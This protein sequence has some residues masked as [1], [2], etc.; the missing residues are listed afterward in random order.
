MAKDNELVIKINGDVKGYQDALKK[1]ANETKDLQDTLNTIAKTGAI[2]F[3][4]FTAAI[5]LS[6]SRFAEFDDGLRGVKTLLDES[7]FSAKTLE[8]GFQDMSKG[9]LKSLQDFPLTLQSLTK[10]LFDIVSAGIPAAKAINVLGSTSRLAVAGIT[11]SAIATDA[12][13][14]ALNAYELSAEEAEL[15]AAK[16]FTA[17]KFGKTTIAELGQF[18]G[19][20]ASSAAAYGVS[21]DELLAA[22][23]AM[24]AGGIKTA[25]AMSAMP[26]VFANV[27]KP[28]EEAKEE[29][30]R[31]GIEFNTTAL[32]AKGLT[33]FLNELTSA[34]GFTKQSVEKL[35][36]SV[37]AQ[38]AIFALTGA[39]AEKYKQTLDAL[40]DSQKTL[41]TFT[42][43]YETQNKSLKNQTI[44]LKNNFDALGISIG[45]N[46][47]PLMETL[48]KITTD[49]L[50]FLQENQGLAAFISKAL[51]TGTVVAGLT[52]IVGLSGL[53]FLKWRIALKA[54]KVA[55]S[56]LRIAVKTL[57]GSTGLG[58]I[59][60]FLPEI[61]D[62]FNSVF[63]SATG[64]VERE[65]AA[66]RNVLLNQTA[67]ENKIIK[68]RL[69]GM[70]EQ[71]IN[72]LR[73]RLR[74]RR[75]FDKARAIQD[76]TEREAALKNTKLTFDL[77]LK[78]EKEFAAKQIEAKSELAAAKKEADK[79]ITDT[80]LR[81][82][83]NENELIQKELDGA[84]K[85]ELAFL[86]RQQDIKIKT[87]EA[88]NEKDK[89]RRAAA[90]ENVKLLSQQLLKDKENLVK[91]QAKLEEEKTDKFLEQLGL[92][93]AAIG[94]SDAAADEKA[95]RDTK[96][97]AD[98]DERTAKRIQKLTDENELIK[99]NQENLEKEEIGFLAR[100]Q[101][102]RDQTTEAG[103]IKNEEERMLALENIRMKNEEL[104]TEE[105]EF[106]IKRDELRAEQQEIET[107]LQEELS[108]LSVEKRMA[109]RD[110]EIKELRDSLETKEQ[111]R[112]KA[113][114][115][116]LLAKRKEQA[117][118]EA[119]EEKHGVIVAE[120]KSFMRSEELSNASVA[121]NSLAQLQRSSNATMKGIGKAAALVQIGINTQKGAIA[122]YSAL[123]GIPVVGP[124][125]GI[126]AAAA[127][128]AFGVEQAARVVAAQDGGVVAGAGFGDRVPF[129]LEPGELITPRQNFEEVI[130]AVAD[131]RV[132]QNEEAEGGET[133]EETSPQEILIG[134]DGEEAADVLTVKQNEQR[135][136]GISQEAF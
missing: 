129:L 52:T 93:E 13:T 134:F 20:A 68:A 124:G 102:L 73:R 135:F 21:L 136:L 36:G 66:Q 11:D 90:L 34:Q 130:N 85:E 110:Q 133:E 12:V 56:G 107:A 69:D 14:S 94:E 31:L 39:G 50:K 27:A 104:L 91:K 117:L 29:A 126:A 17:Q 118:F 45:A 7:S 40:S 19:R 54:A 111:I 80:K 106:F 76:K 18:F 41:S 128:T 71:E 1:A 82:I 127:L 70:S 4:G 49:F 58:L 122:A 57:V 65:A 22:T 35:F 9:A 44:I 113:V 60:A 8:Q 10:S 23:A 88:A 25:A 75:D 47:A 24:T 98:E 84:A 79:K 53:A 64:V 108:Q 99:A 3:A 100:R 62:L 78:E 115:K 2:A 67:D 59:I 74:L 55:T 32:R 46:L 101:E 97:Q 77:I 51:I 105:A 26:A 112:S 121:A 43:A 72:F 30:E 95:N 123:A 87:E 132:I 116:E 96:R 42:K 61:I 81:N 131:R 86:K 63:R 38:K 119:D 15:V 33:G 37:E 89:N 92:E 28:T 5:I 103:K 83:K 48:V 120:F 109:L 114:K 16:F 125:L 6:T